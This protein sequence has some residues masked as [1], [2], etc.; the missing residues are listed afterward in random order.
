L[1][2]IALVSI[3][4]DDAI[5]QFTTKK[6]IESSLIVDTILQFQDGQDAIDYFLKNKTNPDKIPDLVFLDLNMPYLDGWQFLD[7]FTANKFTKELIT[8]YICTSSTS[9]SDF[10]RFAKYSQLDGYLIKPITKKELTETL[11]IE[12]EKR[13]A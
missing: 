5:F 10:D 7:Q 6:V 9:Q 2:K 13:K 8:I 1:K 11:Q 4:D 12:M 3:I